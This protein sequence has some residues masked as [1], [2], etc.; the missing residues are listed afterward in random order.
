MEIGYRK[1]HQKIGSI[2]V[3]EAQELYKVEDI[4]KCKN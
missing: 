2:E 4:Q 3:L 1:S